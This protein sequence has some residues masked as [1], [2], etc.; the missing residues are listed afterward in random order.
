M[1]EPVT[2]RKDLTMGL[3]NTA[4][5]DAPPPKT[6]FSP[7][8][9]PLFSPLPDDEDNDDDV[10]PTVEAVHRWI[11]AE[12]HPI[13]RILR[14]DYLDKFGVP[15]SPE[16]IA[17]A[18]RQRSIPQYRA[19]N[20]SNARAE[21]HKLPASSA[22]SPAVESQTKTPT[23]DE[24]LTAA[25]P[26]NPHK[27]TSELAQY[28]NEHHGHVDPKTL[29]SLETFLPAAKEKNPKQS[30]QALTAY[31]KDRYGA[32]G[33]PEKSPLVA[34]AVTDVPK[35]TGQATAARTRQ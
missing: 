1:A 18:E 23:L 9:F 30:E 13:G 8:T 4:T 6:D 24:F 12:D 10:L 31:W 33:A 2:T 29:P 20:A 35:M 28:W 17:E 22:V 25:G 34:G 27:S 5:K 7:P 21:G 11:D 15:P 32:L 19:P 3:L 26:R 14:M 16:Q